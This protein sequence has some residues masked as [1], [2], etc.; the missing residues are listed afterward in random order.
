MA[1]EK[2]IDKDGKAVAGKGGFPIKYIIGGVVAVAAVI[3]GVLFM[4]Q[5][6]ADEPTV[7]M[8]AAVPENTHGCGGGAMPSGMA[9]PV[10][11]AA[12]AEDK[13]AS[14]PAGEAGEGGKEEGAAKPDGEST[15]KGKEGGEG[16]VPVS[17]STATRASAIYDIDPFM[18]NLSDAIEARFASVTVK[19]KLTHPLCKAD[20][21][22]SLPEIRDSLLML[23]SSKD[24]GTLR[25]SA[26]KLELRDEMMA[27]INPII[28][29]GKVEG[30][31][32][33]E[34]ILQ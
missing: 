8:V 5:K 28:G 17:I 33:T 24:Y 14:E 6:P 34:F 12:A 2:A 25:T 9:T 13:P 32:F 27:R 1:E 19:L 11:V 10:E 26:G 20:V 7:T 29:E 3:G 4:K 30:A 31:Y 22:Q 18:V 15:E 23:I 16:V 21:D